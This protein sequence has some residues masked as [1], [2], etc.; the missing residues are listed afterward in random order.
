MG[1]ILKLFIFFSRMRRCD[2]DIRTQYLM[3]LMLALSTN[4]T[5]IHITKES[6]WTHFIV[7]ISVWLDGYAKCLIVVPVT[8]RRPV[9]CPFASSV[10]GKILPYITKIFMF[11]NFQETKSHIGL[12]QLQQAFKCLLVLKN[13]HCITSI[14]SNA[15]YK[16]GY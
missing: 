12:I 15:W 4:H 7:C 1:R 5:A 14:T 11:S 9:K 10:N 3:H 2:D 6:W 8:Y 16:N 13:I